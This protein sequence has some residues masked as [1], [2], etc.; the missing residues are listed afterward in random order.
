[1]LAGFLQGGSEG[2][3]EQERVQRMQGGSYAAGGA[4]WVQV[5]ALQ[6]A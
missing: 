3:T 6:W 2:E 1:M 5:Q 4:Q